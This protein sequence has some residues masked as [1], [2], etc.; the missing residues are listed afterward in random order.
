MLTALNLSDASH[1]EERT[2]IDISSL[3]VDYSSRRASEI[4][5]AKLKEHGGHVTVY[6]ARGLPCEIYAEADG[7][8]FTSDKLPISPPYEYDVFN[9]IVDLLLKQGGGR[10]GRRTPSADPQLSANDE[11][12]TRD[13]GQLR[14]LSSRDH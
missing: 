2:E 8:T 9:V 10:I 5:K 6:T 14:F 12:Q 7:K 13:A 1:R 4:I 11:V 3:E